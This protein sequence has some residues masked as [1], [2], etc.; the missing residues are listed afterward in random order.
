MSKIINMQSIKGIISDWGKIL[1]LLLDEVIVIS[2]IIFALFYFKI[3][4]PLPVIITIGI[5]GGIFAFILHIAVIPSFHKKKVTGREG[6]IGL[7]GTVIEPLTPVGTISIKGEY[8]K[9]KS[10]NEYVE[11]NKEVEVVEVDGLTLTVKHI[12]GNTGV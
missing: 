10:L 7:K 9:A 3:N 2:G 8:W 4:I 1:I 6:M 12:E 5:I 11:G